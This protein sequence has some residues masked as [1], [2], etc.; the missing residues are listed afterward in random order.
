MVEVL[1]LTGAAAAKAGSNRAGAV[2]E[3]G[4]LVLFPDMAFELT[5][6]ERPLLDP[7]ISNGRSKN[8]SLDPVTGQ[9]RGADVDVETLAMLGRMLG[10]F[11]DRAEALLGELTPRYAGSLQR[12]RT[13]FRPGAIAGRALSRRKD[14]RRLH[15]DAFPSNPTQAGASCGCSPT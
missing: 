14:D 10:R 13:S 5:A 8:V 12:R 11:A 2:L 15:T 6:D 4:G 1:E 7:A 3:A 9:V